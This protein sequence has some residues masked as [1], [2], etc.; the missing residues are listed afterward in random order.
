M[1][2]LVTCKNKEEPIKIEVAR[3]VTRF[4]PLWPFAMETTILIRSGPKPYAA[5]PPPQWCFWWNLITI[6][7]L[8]SEIFMFE[9]VDARTDGQTHGRRLE[10]HTI[11][12]PWAFRSG[13]LT[14]ANHSDIV[15]DAVYTKK[16]THE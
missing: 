4:S 8:V 11:S 5:D 3:V 10:S 14:K 1:I 15:S 7:Q 13:E 2:V 6:G 12:S 16:D 9:S